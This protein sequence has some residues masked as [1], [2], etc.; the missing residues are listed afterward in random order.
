MT[1]AV[2]GKLA[3]SG[4]QPHLVDLLLRIDYNGFYARLSSKR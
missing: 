3:D 2:A 1:A 4:Y